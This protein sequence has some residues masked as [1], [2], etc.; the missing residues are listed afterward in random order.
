VRGRA[1][2]NGLRLAVAASALLVLPACG[3]RLPN[4]S[5]SVVQQGTGTGPG[6]ISAGSNGGS[7]IGSGGGSG[8]GSNGSGT[9]SGGGSAGTSGSGTGGAVDSGG[10][11]SGGSG[12]GSTSG[13]GGGTATGSAT[14]GGST[15]A[16]KANFASDVG[17]TATSITIGNVT[18]IS[19]AF[20]PDAFGPT[21]HG[22]TAY[23][24]A[25]NDQGGINGRKI[26]LVSCDDGSEGTQFLA[27]VQKLVEQD[28]VFALLGNNSD[29]SASG[30]N[31]EYTHGIPDIGFPLNNGYYK[32]PNMF[33][34]YGTPG[35]SRNGK[36]VG[37]NGQI[38]NPLGLYKWFKSN[39]HFTKAAVYYYVIPVSAQAGCFEENGLKQVGVSTVYEGG[40]GSGNCTGAGENPAAPAFDEDVINMRSKGVDTVWDAMDVSANARLCQAMDRQGFKVT[41]KVSTIEVYSQTLGTTFSAPCRDSVYIGGS[42]DSFADTANPLVKQ[43]RSDFAKYQSGANLHQWALEG[44]ALGYELNDAVKAM[45]ANVTRKGFISWLNGFAP[46][47]G[48]YTAG[49]VM[50]PITY[51]PVNFGS[52]LPNCNT[53]AQWQDSAGTYVQRAGPSSCTN[54]TWYSTPATSDGS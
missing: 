13:A 23:V 44:W 49:G 29:A 8:P 46:V 51:A 4:S 12:A 35:Y 25:L 48:G 53:V 7:T 21:L 45:G 11:A 41:A 2:R 27:C 26:K 19:G 33:S 30:A 32:Y 31:Y 9:G 18:S 1:R 37:N 17:V 16:G 14:G 15:G 42:S 38:E 36:A 43:F 3:T 54:A 24:D 10:S 6:G 34:I 20:G 50:T 47:P 52:T 22:L 39:L 40:G 28:H 5:F